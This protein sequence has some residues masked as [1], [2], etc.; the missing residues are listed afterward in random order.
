MFFGAEMLFD[1]FKSDDRQ[2]EKFVALFISRFDGETDDFVRRIEF[3]ILVSKLG[4]FAVA[5]D[6]Q[7]LPSSSLLY[8]P[9]KM[10]PRYIN[11]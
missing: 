4:G 1:F 6:N 11:E 3:E 9:D 5:D 2:A 8:C 10:P 7:S